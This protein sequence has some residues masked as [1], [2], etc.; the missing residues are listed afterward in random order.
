MLILYADASEILSNRQL[1]FF[2]LKDF[3]RTCRGFCILLLAGKFLCKIFYFQFHAFTR[4]SLKDSISQS[5]VHSQGLL[6][7]YK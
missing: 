6:A 3:H 5:V 2:F 7:C 1:S 4:V